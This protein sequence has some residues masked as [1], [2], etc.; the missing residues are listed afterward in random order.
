MRPNE[1]PFIVFH[2]LNRG[3][4]LKKTHIYKMNI[5]SCF[6]LWKISLWT[7]TSRERLLTINRPLKLWG[8]DRM[9]P[10]PK[11]ILMLLVISK[12]KLLYILCSMYKKKKQHTHTQSC[13]CMCS[14]RG[15]CTTLM[16]PGGWGMGVSP[17][18]QWWWNISVRFVCIS[19][20]TGLMR[21]TTSNSASVR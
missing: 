20:T 5:C 21:F 11:N 14:Q 6:Y 1:A 3:K 4:D 13:T 10:I 2:Q 16:L 18:T 17:C 12:R 9:L 15:T 7:I 19:G 8:P